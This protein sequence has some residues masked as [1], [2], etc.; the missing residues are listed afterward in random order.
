MIYSRPTSFAQRPVN[1]L[2]RKPESARLA[3]ACDHAATSDRGGVVGQE[4]LPAADMAALLQAVLGF[5]EDSVRLSVVPPSGRVPPRV[6]RRPPRRLEWLKLL[7]MLL[8]VL[9]IG[10]VRM[11]VSGRAREVMAR[12][13]RAVS[14][15]RQLSGKD[16]RVAEAVAR[17]ITDQLRA[18]DERVRPHGG[19]LGT[20]GAADRAELEAAA[21]ALLAYHLGGRQTNDLRFAAGRDP[22]CLGGGR[23]PQ[24]GAAGACAAAGRAWQASGAGGVHSPAA[25]RVRSSA[26]GG[27]GPLPCRLAWLVGP[28]RRAGRLAGP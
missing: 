2:L 13:Q 1:N 21:G 5:Y 25:E 18:I 22:G 11:V 23:G 4:E 6:L 8:P 7:L 10:L 24:A 20:V 26:A 27:D 15:Y 17:R 12:Q 9:L 14:L 3:A 16:P 19:E 28:A